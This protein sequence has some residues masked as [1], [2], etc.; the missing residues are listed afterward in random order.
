MPT[1]LPPGTIIAFAGPVEQIP[2]GWLLC[3]GRALDRTV[4]QNTALFNHIGSSWGGDA[5]NMFRIPDLR[6]R[7]LRGVDMGAG[8]DPDATSRTASNPGGHQGDDVGTVQDDAFRKHSH[9]AQ[10]ISTGGHNHNI[11]ID[12]SAICGTNMTH[13]VDGGGD[14]WNSDPSLGSLTARTTSAGEHTHDI[15]VGPQ[16]SSET[17][18]LN[19]AVIWII[20]VA[21]D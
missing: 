11:Q 9:Q 21:P 18:P 1:V 14:K 16:G 19:A 6:G 7:F 12:R 20:K 4:P 5:V 13:D 2:A 10:T 15:A 8:R 17:R 3:D